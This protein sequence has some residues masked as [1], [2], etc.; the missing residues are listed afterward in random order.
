MDK[1]PDGDGQEARDMNHL[2]MVDYLRLIGLT[3]CLLGAML[4]ALLFLVQ[5]M[6]KRI[7][8]MSMI[9]LA[10]MPE[11]QVKVKL[12]ELAERAEEVVEKTVERR[13]RT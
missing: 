8:G 10:I 5:R 11:Q 9:L 12:K 6:W 4:V 13:G 1:Y 2:Q 7:E 3:E